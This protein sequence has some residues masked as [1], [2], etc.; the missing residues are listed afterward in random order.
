MLVLLDQSNRVIYSDANV[1]P[2][3]IEAA[4]AGSS[5][6]TDESDSYHISVAPISETPWKLF[7]FV[8]ENDIRQRTATIYHATTLFG[9][10]VFIVA[11]FIFYYSSHR[12]VLAMNQLLREMKKIASGDLNIELKIRKS[13]YLSTIAEALTQMAHRLDNH[14]QNE[15]K[16]VLN[17]RNAEYL[18]LQSQINP[19]FLSNILTSFVTLNRIGKRETLEQSILK[20]SHLFRYIAKNENLSTVFGEMVFIN[21]YLD[22][23]RLR[24]ADKLT[25]GLNYTPETKQIVIPKLLLQPLVENAIVHG[26]EPYGGYLNIKVNAMLETRD[27]QLFLVI[28]ISDNG[29]GFNTELIGP[30]SVGLANII[31]RLELFDSRS[32]FMINSSCGCGCRCEIVLPV[33]TVNI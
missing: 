26:M 5:V 1:E 28:I 24:F 12:T 31:E 11:I 10:G 15:Y 33:N 16:A 8:S 23:Q 3:L 6:V 14:I 18:A 32:Q 9:L 17:Q 20:L 21:E 22:L 2:E 7:Y 4:V 27:E 13:G 30:D 25:F 29:E 19:H